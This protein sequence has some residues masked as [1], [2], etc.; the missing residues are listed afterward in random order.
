MEE[1]FSSF[2]KI[3]HGNISWFNESLYNGAT[4][5]YPNIIQLE[6][7]GVWNMIIELW[8]IWQKNEALSTIWRANCSQKNYY[9]ICLTSCQSVRLFVEPSLCTTSNG[10][11]LRCAYKFLCQNPIWFAT[12]HEY[13]LHSFS[14]FCTDCTPLLCVPRK[15]LS[16]VWLTLHNDI[17]WQ[18]CT[19]F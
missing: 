12:G 2:L 11:E 7:K 3:N 15:S 18:V 14:I 1:V 4:I 16:T 6:G 17:S 10:T 9:C 13:W 8:C 19:A 5:N